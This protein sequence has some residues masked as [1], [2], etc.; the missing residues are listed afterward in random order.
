M[1][2]LGGFGFFQFS[3]SEVRKRLYEES[4]TDSSP[5]LKPLAGNLFSGNAPVGCPQ[6]TQLPGDTLLPNRVICCILKGETASDLLSSSHSGDAKAV[7]HQHTRTPPP[8]GDWSGGRGADAGAAPAS[9]IRTGAPEL[10]RIQFPR[11]LTPSTPSLACR[12]LCECGR[13]FTVSFPFCLYFSAL[14]GRIL[15]ME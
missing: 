4:V 5:A 9:G 13:L 11:K 1:D 7:S 6:P 2:Q 15:I 3:R 8:P 12:L 14:V 10:G